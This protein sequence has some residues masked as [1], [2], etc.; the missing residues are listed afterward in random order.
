[1]VKTSISTTYRTVEGWHVFVS[2]DLPGLYVASKDLQ[3][4]YDDVVRSIQSLLKLDE[5]VDCEVF[6]EV[7]LDEFLAMLRGVQ[8]ENADAV[9]V[10][11]R[12]A[13]RGLHA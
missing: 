6:P 12:F 13:V 11:R 5:D 1:M 8:S 10:H 3:S 4:A 9:Q 2:D 7:P